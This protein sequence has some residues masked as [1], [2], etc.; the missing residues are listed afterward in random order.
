MGLNE[1]A[2]AFDVICVMMSNFSGNTLKD[3]AVTIISEQSIMSNLSRP[4]Q[5]LMLETFQLISAHFTGILI[6]VHLQSSH[7]AKGENLD[8]VDLEYIDGR[9]VQL[10]L[11]Q[12]MAKV[13]H[14]DEWGSKLRGTKTAMGR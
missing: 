1:T 10:P 2:F 5:T 3:T 4:S 7:H 11:S 12:S 6:S 13:C 14:V 9:I 8:G